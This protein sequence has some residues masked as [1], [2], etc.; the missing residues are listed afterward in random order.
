ME[1][2][3]NKIKKKYTAILAK[4]V[5]LVNRRNDEI[6]YNLIILH[7]YKNSEGRNPISVRNN[8]KLQLVV[9]AAASNCRCPN[10]DVN[11]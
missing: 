3:H 8:K 7:T 5:G 6:R 9:P 10:L 4:V 2:N 11:K 1:I